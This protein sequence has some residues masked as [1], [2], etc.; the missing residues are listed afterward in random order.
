MLKIKICY[1]ME[2]EGEKMEEQTIKVKEKRAPSFM[3]NVVILMCS[4]LLVKILGFIYKIVITNVEGFGDT[5]VGYY[6]AGAQIYSLL[7]TL[8]STGIPSA[9]SK[10]VSERLA[11]GDKVGAQRIF[12]I[13]LAFFTVLGLVFSLGLFFGADFIACNI[14]NIPDTA[15]VMKVL[16]P[17][18]VFVSISS[19]L[20][21][22]FSGQQNMKPTSISQ[23]LEQ[24]LNC[25][26][27]IMFVYACVGKDAYIMA[28][29]G[30]LST[31]LSIL[32]S[33][34]YMVIYY[35]RKR[36]VPEEGQISPERN[37]T[38]RQLL[39]IVLSIAIPLTIGSIISVI[40]SVIDTTIISNCIQIAYADTGMTKEALENLAMSKSGIITKVD[41]LVT[42]PI[43]INTA[44]ATALIPAIS[45]AIAKKDYK[46]ANKKMR[47]SIFATILIILPCAMG[48][49]ILA[50]PVL[51]MLYPA[52]SD[53]TFV[54]QLSTISM[55]FLALNYT[56]NG[57][58]YGLNKTKVPVIA[59]GIG[60]IIKTVLGIVLISNPDINI[61]GAV[62][63]SIVC[64]LISFAICFRVLKINLNLKFD[65]K[66]MILKPLI[67]TAIMGVVVWLSYYILNTIIG[68]TLSTV[69]SIVVGVIVYLIAIISLKALSKDDILSIP[70]GNKIYK[71][72][73]K[74]H[75]YKETV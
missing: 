28:A 58:L 61:I 68:N 57:G 56:I 67:A 32:I 54:L 75:F 53:G 20:T 43:A 29:A 13:A 46:S 71:I 9:I 23:T 66:K 11:I 14:L 19:V 35:K 60:I 44:F 22:Y 8:S 42:F 69:I 3:R 38:N 74:L 33:F 59:L 15:L 24:F 16:A 34:T 1:D 27:S 36:I 49:T 45:E 17:G 6:S 51:K 40:G 52:A 65:K 62:I 37:K 50:E 4:H 21:G 26:L 2:N 55:I 63:G 48:L 64:Q 47:F 30:N 18:I 5:G 41:T 10:L 12:K 39:K 73:V 72:L 25:V 31:T 7:L 70:F